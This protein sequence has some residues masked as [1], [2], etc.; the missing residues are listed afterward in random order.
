MKIVAPI[1]KISELEPVLEAG[2]DEIYFGMAPED[3]LKKFGHSSMSRRMFG[4]IT[5]YRDMRRIIDTTGSAGKQAML[6][7]N[8]QQY[9][10][11]QAECLLNLAQRFSEEGGAAIIIADAALLLEISQMDLGTRLHLSS[12]AACRNTQ[13]AELFKKFGADRIIFPRYMK[14]SEIKAMINSLPE[15]EFEAFVLNDGCIY[16]EGVCH[17]LHLPQQYGGPICLDKYRHSYYRADGM[18]ID[19]A[20]QALLLENEKDYA[21]WTWYKFSCGFATTKQGYTFGPCGLCAIDDFMRNGLTAIKIAGREAPLARKIKSIELVK[22]VR[23][24]VLEGANTNEIFN[25]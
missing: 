25:Y 22:S 11:Q 6:V 3:W 20:E 2:A 4:N 8:A 16:E 14:I 12:I 5:D 15:L 24:K 19:A 21:E 18:E 7:L 9:T 23:D 10:Q 13:S 17:T 1:S